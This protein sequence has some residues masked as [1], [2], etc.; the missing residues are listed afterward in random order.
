M[1]QP[2]TETR[3]QLI[4]EHHAELEQDRRPAQ[5]APRS[6][7]R[8]ARPLPAS[9]AQIAAESRPGQPT[10]PRPDT[11]HPTSPD[12]RRS[13]PGRPDQGPTAM[14][15]PEGEGLQ[16]DGHATERGR[17]SPPRTLTLGSSPGPTLTTSEARA[18]RRCL[19]RRGI[20]RR[21]CRS[22]R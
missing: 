6:A 20:E 22:T 18:R 4:R 5:P 21:S 2:D 17:R 11:L 13:T 3:R 12:D 1:L 10:T 16:V 8:D 9:P 14:T 15:I 7:G 19:S